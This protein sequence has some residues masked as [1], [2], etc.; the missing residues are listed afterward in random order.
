[1]IFQIF[2]EKWPLSKW[3]FSEKKRKSYFGWIRKNPR[4]H[5]SSAWNWKFWNFL[6]FSLRITYTRIFADYT[7]AMWQKCLTLLTRYLSLSPPTCHN[8]GS[9]QFTKPSFSG[10]TWS[11]GVISGKFSANPTLYWAIQRYA[12][13]PCWCD[14]PS[15]TF[16]ISLIQRL[17]FGEIL[18]VVQTQAILFLKS[19]SERGGSDI[20]RLLNDVNVNRFSV[21]LEIHH[22]IS[23][24]LY[25]GSDSLRHWFQ[26]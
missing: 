17:W 10:N 12:Y 16:E 7:Y 3:Q 24:S 26:K 15:I 4:I 21:D 19:M 13:G 9:F 22:S 14:F 11:G 20:E 18:R 2:N 6:E 25:V 8:I 23:A 1:M 5:P